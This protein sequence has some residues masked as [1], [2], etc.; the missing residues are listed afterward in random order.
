GSKRA[1][2]LDGK[3]DEWGSNGSEKIAESDGPVREV[4]A[5]KDEQYL[6]L[7]LRLDKAESWREHPITI[8]L[9]VRPVGTRRL[10]DHPGVFPAAARRARR[11]AGRGGAAV[12]VARPCR[13]VEPAGVRGASEGRGGEGRR[14]AR[15]DCRDQRGEPS[16]DDER[17]CVGAVAGGRVERTE[18]GRL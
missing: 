13:A 9:D 18:E 17:V 14:G 12:A 4:R 10:P 11:R 6:Y 7:L 16:A 3:D 8:G 2:V 1:V 15:R 5:V